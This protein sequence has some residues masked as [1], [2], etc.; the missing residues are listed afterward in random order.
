QPVAAEAELAGEGERAGPPL[1]IGLLLAA[2]GTLPGPSP[3][4]HAPAVG[5]ED[6]LRGVEV[7]AEVYASAARRLEAGGAVRP[8]DEITDQVVEM[9]SEDH[10][11]VRVAPPRQQQHPPSL[12]RHELRALPE[13]GRGVL[14]G[15]RM[16]TVQQ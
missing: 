3:A 4:Q 5:V 1:G 15:D 14:D 16:I 6:G 13:V 10:G 8:I 7:R 9:D 2:L 11:A 12:E